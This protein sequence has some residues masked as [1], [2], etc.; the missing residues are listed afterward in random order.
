MTEG[1]RNTSSQ[2][3]KIRTDDALGDILSLLL[4]WAPIII[5]GSSFLGLVIDLG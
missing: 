3:S 5:V 2:D 1:Q 4:R